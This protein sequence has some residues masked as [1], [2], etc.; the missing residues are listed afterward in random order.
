MTRAELI[1]IVHKRLGSL[2]TEVDF[3]ADEASYGN[4]VDYALRSLRGDTVIASVAVEDRNEL[5]D[6]TEQA[7]YRELRNRYSLYVDIEIGPRREKFNQ[8]LKALDKLIKPGPMVTRDAEYEFTDFTLYSGS[9][10]WPIDW[11]L[12]NY[13][14]WELY[15]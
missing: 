3:A 6:L 14:T 2:A 12:R 7:A 9:S 15:G 11:W 8:T 4:A 1:T 13:E 5:I 10:T